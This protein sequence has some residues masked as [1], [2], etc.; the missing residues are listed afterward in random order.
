MIFQE[1]VFLNIF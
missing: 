1:S